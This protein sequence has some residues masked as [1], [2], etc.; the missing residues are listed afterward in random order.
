MGRISKYTEKEYLFLKKI[1]RWLI[2]ICI[3][4]WAAEGQTRLSN[5][6]FTHWR[7]KKWQ[8]TPVFLAGESQ[9]RGTWWA[10]VYGVTQSRTR[11][12]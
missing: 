8:P 7:R 3:G 11:L 10:N 1:Y 5:L 2:G 9:G 4:P 12:K 6:T